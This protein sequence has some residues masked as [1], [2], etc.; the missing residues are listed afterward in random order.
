MAALYYTPIGWIPCMVV[1]KVNGPGLLRH[2]IE[3]VEDGK[4]LRRNVEPLA[5]KR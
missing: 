4:R 5:I 1:G 3:Y 2:T